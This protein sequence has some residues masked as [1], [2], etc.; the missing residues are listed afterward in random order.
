MGDADAVCRKVGYKKKRNS[1][2]SSHAC[3]LS[4]KNRLRKLFV[5]VSAG[6][7]QRMVNHVDI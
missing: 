5:V 3:C 1:E 4:L 2:R 6:R 7:L